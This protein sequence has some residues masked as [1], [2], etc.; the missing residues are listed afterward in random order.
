[1][2]SIGCGCQLRVSCEDAACIRVQ[3]YLAFFVD[4]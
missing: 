3:I 1:M 4:I 2:E